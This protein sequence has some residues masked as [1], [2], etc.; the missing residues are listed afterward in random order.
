MKILLVSYFFPPFNSVGAVRV[1]KIAKYLVEAG[2]EVRVLTA[3]DQPLQRTLTPEIPQDQVVSTSWLNINAP[4]EMLGGGRAKV[5][6]VGYTASSGNGAVRRLIRVLG[7]Q[8]K[9]LTNFPDGQIGWLPYGVRGGSELLGSW[10]P[11]II[12]ASGLPWTSLLI[13]HRLA[14]KFDV[15]WAAELRDLW[16]DNVYGDVVPA[17]RQF[18][19]RRLERRVLRTAA[20]F[21]STSDVLAQVLERKYE[22]P[23]E[24]IL[25]GFD[26]DDYPAAA[27]PGAMGP[28]RIVYTGMI[29]EGRRDPG[30]LFRALRG[31]G[32]RAD[33][34]RVTFYGKYLDGARRMAQQYG[35]EALVDVNPPVSHAEALEI[36][37]NAD[38]LLLLLWNHPREDGVCPGKVYEYFGA[39]RPVLVL[40]RQ[41]NFA[42]RLISERGAGVVLWGEDEIAAQLDQWLA[43]KRA[44]GIPAVPPAAA[45]GLTHR[46]QTER[47]AG[48][49]E[50][51]ARSA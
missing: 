24:G 42:A 23:A 44:G 25:T 50:R 36:Q 8:Y 39:R 6:S 15:P 18:L 21:V 28:L 12:Y 9:Y 7:T 30:P 38:I 22:K 45:Q 20:G 41:Q 46:E 4:A 40:G 5:A 14:R 13:G 27:E 10:R 43:I 11:D 32:S 19:D 35:V 33:D 16:V 17:W 31:M 34:I 26:P 2:H 51:L 37:A 49:L 1:G 47:L 48:F 29:Y 3:A